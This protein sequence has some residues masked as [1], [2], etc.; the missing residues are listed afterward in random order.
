[1]KTRKYIVVA[2]DGTESQITSGGEKL[3]LSA[4]QKLVGGYIERTQ[5]EH[6]GK[7]VD[8]WVNEEGLMHNLPMNKRYPHLAGVVVLDVV[9][10]R[11]LKSSLMHLLD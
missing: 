10:S 9:H 3:E 6:G 2:V 4:L 11:K 7:S 1:M 8:A 5:V